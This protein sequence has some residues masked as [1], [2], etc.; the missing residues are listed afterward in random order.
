MREYSRPV[1]QNP[2]IL[3]PEDVCST[4]ACTGL[5]PA[6][7]CTDSAADNYAELYA[8][9]RQQRNTL[10]TGEEIGQG[11]RMT[12]PLGSEAGD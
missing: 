8:I 5:T 6:A 9:H 11:E 7:V 4:T 2:P 12:P 3:E 1:P 10:A